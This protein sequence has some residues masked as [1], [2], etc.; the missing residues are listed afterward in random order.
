MLFVSGCAENIHRLYPLID[1][2]ILLSAPIDTIMARVGAQSAYGY[3]Y[4]QEEQAKIAALIAM[5]EPLLREAAHHE[6][7]ISGPVAGTV[8]HILSLLK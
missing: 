7:D 3:G 5:I 4:R 1:R 2:T 6:V 8:N